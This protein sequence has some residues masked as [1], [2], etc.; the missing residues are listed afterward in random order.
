VVQVLAAMNAGDDRFFVA[1]PRVR[2]LLF[3]AKDL[4]IVA[5]LDI[6][7]RPRPLVSTLSEK[8]AV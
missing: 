2:D 1:L 6:I 3:S 7:G 4:F 8:P 5:R